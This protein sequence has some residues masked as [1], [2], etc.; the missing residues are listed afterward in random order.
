MINVVM[1]LTMLM[2]VMMTW[3]ML[4]SKNH[5]GTCGGQKQ[6]TRR[7]NGGFHVTNTISFRLFFRAGVDDDYMMILV[8]IIMIL[9]MIM[10]ALMIMMILMMIMMM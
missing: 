6:T 3:M 4:S 7:L 8:M 5:L 10:M 9:V 2:M 1:K